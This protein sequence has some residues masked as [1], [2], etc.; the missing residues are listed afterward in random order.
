MRGNAKNN[1][2]CKLAVNLVPDDDWDGAHKIVQD[3]NCNIAQWIHAVLHKIEGD[4]SNSKYWYA[5]SSLAK[6]EDYDNP[7]EELLHILHHIDQIALQ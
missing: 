3:L 7:N 2:D 4:S 1:S 5:R 6:Y